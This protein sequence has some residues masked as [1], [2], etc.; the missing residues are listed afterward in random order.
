MKGWLFA[1]F[2]LLHAPLAAGFAQD[3]RREE[4]LEAFKEE[5]QRVLV[6]IGQ[7]HL[8]Y[9]V[10]LR[11]KGLHLQ[12]AM[13]LVLAVDASRGRNERARVVLGVMRRYQD[14]FW[15]RR[16]A[17]PTPARLESYA[18]KAG[19]LRLQ[20]QEDLFGL[21]K[22]AEKKRLDEQAYDELE[23]LL[24]ALDEPLEF[25]ERGALVLAGMK[26]DGALA[27]RVRASAIE[28]NGRPYVRDIVLRRVPEIR[29]VFESTSPGLRVRSTRSVED[30]AALHAAA[31][32][33]LP[34]LS[35]ELGLIPDRRLQIFVLGERKRY[36][37]YLDIAGLS[38][39]RAAD[40]FADRVANAAVLCSEGSTPEFVLGLALHELT[41]LYQ[42]SVS[43][44][45]FPS[46][47][48]E[49]CAETFGGEGTFRWDG[50]TLVVGEK[51]APGRLDELRAAPMPLRDLLAADALA[52]LA[53][54]RAAAR[55]FYAGAWAFLRFLEE[56]AG[57]AVAEQLER[58][59]DA[60][61]GSIL[62]ADLYKP[63]LMD[64]GGSHALFLELF[65]PD[66]ARLETEFAAW[67]QTL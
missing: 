39:H 11:D 26:L 3:G 63:Y 67:L 45:A 5:R 37:A 8:E 44:A 6:Q 66:L 48:M 36:N 61:L 38:S 10:E 33:L 21:V 9:G 29:H 31:T 16:P 32:A 59:R 14:A 57:P 1:A 27:E 20:G 18:K 65:E 62:G 51:M 34:V 40:G 28:I 46:W 7:R 41:H 30:S 23:E 54:D 35:A 58:W 64:S 50:H 49:G 53:Q 47:Y 19:K 42:L 17:A 22:W 2:A 56:G 12:A 52:L 55:R 15:K 13:Q 25:D 4:A 43:P 24:L 60:C